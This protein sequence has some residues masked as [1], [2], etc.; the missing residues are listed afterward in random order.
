MTLCVVSFFFHD[1]NQ[2]RPEKVIAGFIHLDLPYYLERQRPPGI[3]FLLS[4]LRT[5]GTHSG[6]S[7][8]LSGIFLLKLHG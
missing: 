2:G 6:I 8:P 7:A 5:F 4:Y 1:L 3:L